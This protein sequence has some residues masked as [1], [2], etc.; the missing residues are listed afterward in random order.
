MRFRIKVIELGKSENNEIIE[1]WQLEIRKLAYDDESIYQCQLPLIQP[2]NKH[3]LLKVKHDLTLT[4]DREGIIQEGESIRLKCGVT[5]DKRKNSLNNTDNQIKWFKNNHRIHSHIYTTLSHAYYLSS[6][7]TIS[8]SRLLH[9]GNYS[10]EFD[11]TRESID[12][13]V[14]NKS[15][16]INRVSTE[17]VA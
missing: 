13:K 15:N 6:E 11:G 17:I 4:I 16:F 12:I 5:L 7:L 1:N 2:Q 8:H 3:V 10:C 14:S 9:D